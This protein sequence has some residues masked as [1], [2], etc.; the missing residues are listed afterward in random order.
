VADAIRRHGRRFYARYSPPA[1]ARRVLDA[2]AACRTALLG[3]HLEKCDQCGHQRP[4]YNSCRNRH[5]PKCQ[6]L[7]RSD[8]VA[9]RRRELLPVPYFHLVFT[10]PHRLNPLLLAN[11][12]LLVALLF[13]AVSRTLVEF[14]RSRLG[15][16]MGGTAVLHTW[17]QKLL[18]HF[19]LH[20]LVPGGALA[21]GAW[22]PAPKRFLFPVRALS[23]VFQAKFLDGLNLLFEKGRLELPPELE[24]L[25]DTGAFKRWTRG[26]GRAPWVVFAKAAPV[27]Q[28][29]VVLEYL[30][31]YTARVAISNRRIVEV[32]D[33]R[34]TFSYRDR[35][36]GGVAAWMTLEGVEFVRRF[37]L[38]VLP[39]GLQRVR[40]FGFLAN[41][42]KK[43][44]LA[45]CRQFL[46]APEPEPIDQGD[47]RQRL[48]KRHGVDP[49]TCPCCGHGTMRPE[50]AIPPTRLDPIP[51]LSEGRAVAEA[52]SP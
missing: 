16:L 43:R 50:R 39:P 35:R 9:E 52:R 14:G 48:L 1:Y 4:A 17:D 46:E 19:H 29:E 8:W 18:D 24:P 37:L 23:R 21:E 11:K 28:P 13:R 36:A 20:C 22:N 47:W 33:D 51:A 12:R 27:A 5:C 7:A 26:L 38:H 41:R 34:V 30:A 10:L 3:G 45:R 42:S 32:S 6:G 25:R 31:R 15:G 40:S 44:N 49:L 2:L